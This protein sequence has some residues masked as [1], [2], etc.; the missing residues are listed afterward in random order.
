MLR[1]FA[2]LVSLLTTQLVLADEVDSLLAKIRA[3]V[4]EL[5]RQ[6]DSCKY[7][8]C[9]LSIKSNTPEH[10]SRK[11]VL[12]FKR[13]GDNWLLVNSK[14]YVVLK[15]PTSIYAF[16]RLTETQPWTL[17]SLEKHTNETA[18]HKIAN[19]GISQ[20]INHLQ[21]ASSGHTF[22]QILKLKDFKITSFKYDSEDT[23]EVEYENEVPPSQVVGDNEANKVPKLARGKM[24]C[25]PKHFW[26]V[27]RCETCD[28]V[29]DRNM[30][31]KVVG[32]ST[33]DYVYDQ[34]KIEVKSFTEEVNLYNISM[35]TTTTYRFDSTGKYR[36][37][38][39]SPAYYGIELP[40]IPVP[41]EDTTSNFTKYI[42]L[43]L[44][45]LFIAV[46]FALYRFIKR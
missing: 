15:D 28:T 5:K 14:N 41:Y 17:A 12:E 7:V 29:T 19:S 37:E 27:K 22:E 36:T 9:K 10:E 40:E 3:G 2:I 11:P 39:F 16:N 26:I 45:I 18:Q 35:K 46:S 8:E 38:E 42:W 23:A 33:R 1:T 24:I 21:S 44:G 31:A 30:P 25:V 4:S 32:V 13:N 6:E 34:G 43:A 20:V